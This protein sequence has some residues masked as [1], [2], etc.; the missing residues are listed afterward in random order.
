M[1]RQEQVN[2]IFT[3]IDV[4]LSPAKEAVAF[5]GEVTQQKKNC[6]GADIAEL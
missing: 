5:N 3:P 2:W 6:M 4:F 1:V